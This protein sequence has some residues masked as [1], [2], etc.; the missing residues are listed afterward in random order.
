MNERIAIIDPDVVLSRSMSQRIMHLIPDSKVS[1]YTP[2]AIKSD[3]SLCLPEGI[4]FYDE[5][6]T[7]PDLLLRHTADTSHP[8]LIPLHSSGTEGRRLLTGTELSRM[9]REASA[10]IRYESRNSGSGYGADSDSGCGADACRLRE[11]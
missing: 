5:E 11:K 7:D 8:H 4:I 10:D 3:E 1:F 6:G 9:I 2:D